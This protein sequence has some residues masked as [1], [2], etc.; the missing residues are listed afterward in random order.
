MQTDRRRTPRTRP[1]GLAYINLEPD[2]GGIVLDISEEGLC[3][4]SVAPVQPDEVIRF[5]FSAEGDRIEAEGHLAWIKEKGKM[6]GVQFNPL[7]P[8]AHRQIHN[9]IAQP[10][11][12]FG[13]ESKPAVPMPPSVPRLVSDSGT[14]TRSSATSIA[15]A[16]HAT[17][18]VFS[19]WLRAPI[20]W[21]EF[22]R[23]LAAGFLVSVFVVGALV[24]Q[25]HRR[26][27]G[28]LLIRMGER[29]GATPRQQGLAPAP[30]H[31]AVAQQRG[32]AS[33][34]APKSAPRAENPL[35]RPPTRPLKFH[36]S[37][38][39]HRGQLQ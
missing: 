27:V 3:F 6:G 7:S 28:E 29:F 24:F 22:F 25:M 37:K 8:E 9:W 20:R 17:W 2:N 39:K 36:L 14:F 35:S 19:Q 10:T 16:V 11:T 13:A 1:E 15:G 32:V 33:D 38:R 23:C 30:V 34:P 31:E 12:P 4:Q 5:W 26:Q 18:D 21:T